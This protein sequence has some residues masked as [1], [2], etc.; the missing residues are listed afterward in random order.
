MSTK[1]SGEHAVDCHQDD[2]I[3]RV[4][5]TVADHE[6]RIRS[7]EKELADGNTRFV[8]LEGKLEAVSE[9]LG[10][11]S[12]TIKGAVRWVLLTVGTAAAGAIGW[13]FIMSKGGTP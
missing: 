6:V 1:R 13:A 8:R 3:S 11:L 2:R 9:K 4:E 10:E 12:D 5:A 7:S